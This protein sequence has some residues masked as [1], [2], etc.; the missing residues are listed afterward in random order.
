MSGIVDGCPENVKMVA[1]QIFMHMAEFQGTSTSYGQ[2]AY[3]VRAENEA[4]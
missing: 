1:Q 2:P 4:S 3:R